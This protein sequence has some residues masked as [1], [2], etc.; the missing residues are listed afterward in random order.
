M[1]EERNG[2][3]ILGRGSHSLYFSARHVGAEEQEYLHLI[4]FITS[5]YCYWR[6]GVMLM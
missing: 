6:H 3:V 2:S 1:P 5:T 4:L